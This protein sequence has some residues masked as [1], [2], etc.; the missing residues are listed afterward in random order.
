MSTSYRLKGRWVAG[1]LAALALAAAA[2][3]SSSTASSV[4]SSATAAAG[5]GHQA[6]GAPIVV[7]AMG[8]FTGPGAGSTA[9]A[10]TVF[11]DWVSWT[12]A[13][14]GIDGHPVKAIILNDQNSPSTALANAEQLVQ[15]DKVLTIFD[16]SDD[17]ESDWASVVD[18]AGVPVI[19]QSEGPQ[20]LTDP[21]F[22]STGTTVV[23]LL[24]GEL[25]AA[26]LDKVSK[27]GVFYCAEIASC[28][29]SIPLIKQFGASEGVT[30]S[31]AAEISSTA[32]SYTAQCLG[33]KSS[34]ATG[35]TVVA[36]SNVVL[37]VAESCATQGYHPV[38]VTTGGEM[39][40]TWLKNPAVN[41]SIGN[42][43]DVPWFDD[44]TPATRTMQAALAK[45]SPGLA[46][47]SAF[48]ATATIAWA[49]GVVF[50]TVAR[51]AGLTPSSSPAALTAALDQVHDDT[52]GGLTPPLTYTA[53]QP[54]SV[55]CSFVVGLKNG[56]W[57]EPMG[58]QTVCQPA[59]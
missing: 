36:A 31:Y 49:A 5:G 17:L 24:W 19:G 23:S 12:N 1:T 57:T 26:H 32:S 28:S 20:F 25:A 21:D 53:G 4:S 15:Q 52:F 30:A 14:G 11:E 58:L 3:G 35:V 7:G 42:V 16:L 55:P 46:D 41:G 13:N 10:K 34:G 44:S 56:H 8:S 51:A 33:A 18:K 38:W 29:Q 22:Y 54:H 27:L 45:Y 37:N 50:D 48:G 39:T 47:N 40:T 43:Q 59:G 6:T 9:D 2:C